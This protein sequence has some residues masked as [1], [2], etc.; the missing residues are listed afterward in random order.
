MFRQPITRREALRAGVGLGASAA[1]AR[2]VHTAGAAESKPSG[3]NILFLMSDQ[4]RGDCLGADGNEAIHTPNLDRLAAE[5]ARF[6]SAYTS[7]PSCTPA[8]AGILTGLSPWH[9]GQIGYGRVARRYDNELPRL[10]RAAGYDTL[11]IGKMHFYPQR[12]TH[13]YHRTILDESGRVGSPGFVSDYRQ[14]FRSEA[15]DLDPDA[16]GIGWNDHRGRPYV[17]PERLHPTAWTGQQAIDYLESYQ[18]SAP[19]LLKVSFARPHSPY[20]APPRWWKHYDDV[21]LPERAI[22]DWAERHAQRG[23]P[24][25]DDLWQGDLGPEKPRQARQGYYGNTSFIDEQIGRILDALESRGWLENTLILYAADHGDMLGD[26]H[27][28]RKTYGYEPSARVPM[29]LRW[30]KGLL[31]AARGQVRTEPVE[32]RDILPTFLD[33]AGIEHDPAEFDGRSMLS[34]VRGQTD[35][36]R[37]YIDL[38]HARCYGGSTNWTGLT[39][40][41]TKYIYHADDGRQQLFDLVADP[42]ETRDLASDPAHQTELRT[43]RSRMIDHLAERGEPFVTGGD[44][45]LRRKPMIYSPNYPRGRS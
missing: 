23:Q 29:L 12:N 6:C 44:L 33:A 8:R 27:L 15:P 45:G 1:L 37:E 19:F 36:W 24:H 17:L 5:G 14:W 40:G 21:D 38:E 3:P 31:S 25:R 28:W 18:K 32:L 41:K 22:G 30:P 43:W 2:M 34:L 16:T 11:G 9:H 20:D 13:G 26:H 35:G 10:I 39:D 7:V 42:Q 4:H